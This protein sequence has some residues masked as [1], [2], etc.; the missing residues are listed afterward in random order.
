MP[1]PVIQAALRARIRTL[2]RQPNPNGFISDLEIN[3]LINESAYELYDLLIAS[4]GDAYYS[5]EWAFNTDPG[6]R[7]YLLPANFYRLSA[8]ILS[9]TPGNDLGGASPLGVGE[10]TVT[11]PSSGAIWCPLPRINYADWAKQENL[12]GAGGNFFSPPFFENT[13]TLK[14][15]LT[16][17]GNAGTNTQVAEIAIFPAPQGVYCINLIYIPTLD[18]SNDPLTQEPVYDGIN[19]WEDFI[20][21]SVAS[22]IADMQEESNSLFLS[23]R[24]SIMQRIQQ[25]APGKDQ[26]SNAKV[27][28]RCLS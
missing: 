14:Y 20:V 3:R 18:L 12:S 5:V 26:A 11:P 28:D 16:G 25:L 27:S 1:S 8:I 7:R 23:K 4:R 21:Y 2:V 9:S 22:T 17:R 6:R 10:R 13:T 24:K 19:G 15:N